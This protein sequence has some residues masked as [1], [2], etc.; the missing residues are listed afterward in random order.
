[1]TTV[2]SLQIKLE[3][4]NKGLTTGLNQADKS[5]NN[6]SSSASK[7]FAGVAAAAGAA[8]A[9]R[10]LVDT[11]TRFEKLEASL[12]TVTGSA[13]AADKEFTKL[14]E[15]AS[16]TPFQLDEVVGAFIK[17]K[18]LG[19]DPS[20]EALNSFGNTAVA[21]GKSLNQ[22][23]EAVA[24]AATGEFERLKEFGIRAKQQGDNVTFIFQGVETTI[25]KSASNI[26]DY[27][28][29]IGDQQFGGAMEEQADTLGTALSNLED[30]FDNLVVA[31]GDSGLTETLASIAQSMTSI[32]NSTTELIPTFA[33]WGATLAQASPQLNLAY[34]FLQSFNDEQERSL[35]LM[36]KHKER[37][38][39]GLGDAELLPNPE[40][41]RD[42]QAEIEQSMQRHLEKLVVIR[43]NGLSE[44]ERFN[45][46]SYK[47]QAKTVFGHLD[48]IT[49]GVAQHNRALFEANKVA[50]IASAVINAYEGIS[51]TL[52]SYPFPLNI[53]LAAAHGA[54]AFAQVNAIRSTSFGGGGG[55]SA[56][57]I[58]A[59]TPATP[60]T[61]T[62]SGGAAQS[63]GG[64]SN[65]LDVVVNGINPG[66]LIDINVLIERL[67][68]ATSDGSTINS[69]RVG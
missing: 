8:L 39:K 62:S 64:G 45:E 13:A 59:S 61:P 25:E 6:F 52:A 51:K 5:I 28:K 48:S 56:P 44:L 58:A 21:M 41:L 57:S 50:G 46:S 35:D 9:L 7:A 60:V 55:G 36:E 23:I 30:S 16:T 24:D 40:V 63:S 22:F 67:N 1:M 49:A 37:Q 18:A 69:V 3:V 42:R 27:L 17:M 31:I 4:D 11:V 34:T 12:R 53:G 32:V 14:K 47:D 10:G 2:D 29:R 65:A 19:L 26:Q 66:E 38:E 43:K 54:A 68:E 15:F 33:D 20:T